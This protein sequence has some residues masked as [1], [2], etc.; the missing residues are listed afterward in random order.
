[1]ASANVQKTTIIWPV[2]LWQFVIRKRS[3]FNRSNAVLFLNLFCNLI[4]PTPFPN[5]L[6]LLLQPMF[7]PGMRNFQWDLHVDWSSFCLWF[8]TF[9][10]FSKNEAHT[11]NGNTGQ[12][13]AHYVCC[14]Q[15]S[16]L[17]FLRFFDGKWKGNLFWIYMS[18]NPW[19]NLPT[20]TGKKQFQNHFFTYFSKPILAMAEGSCCLPGFPFPVGL[21]HSLRWLILAISLLAFTLLY[22]NNI[23]F[24][25]SVICI[26]RPSPQEPVEHFF[27]HNHSQNDPKGCANAD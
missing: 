25:F 17:C 16:W 12:C 27:H 18:P 19:Q 4:A 14:F 11:Q 10:G 8:C 7:L 3:G 26:I 9:W 13:F 1:M 24:N 5:V 15:N 20:K 2:V 23:T 22:A 6:S 21:R